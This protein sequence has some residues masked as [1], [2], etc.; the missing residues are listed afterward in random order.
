MRVLIQSVETRKYLA[1]NGDWTPALEEARNF[2][3]STFAYR[4][5]VH[6]ASGRFR[7]VLHFPTT[8]EL[9]SILEGQ[10]RSRPQ[11]AVG[12]QV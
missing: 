1:A 5:G 11:A 9:I 12:L 3:V 4:C 6:A 10:G 7:V 8:R 2:G